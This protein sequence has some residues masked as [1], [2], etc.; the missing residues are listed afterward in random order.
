MAPSH[1]SFSVVSV[2]AV[3]V[4]LLS[5]CWTASVEG[6]VSDSS[7]TTSPDIQRSL[8]SE[9]LINGE[10]SNELDPYFVEWCIEGTCFDLEVAANTEQRMKGLMER[11]VLPEWTGMVFYFDEPGRHAFWM[12]NTLIPLDVIWVWV[13]NTVVDIHT[14]Q[15][16]RS[17]QCPSTI[18][19][20]F[21]DRVIEIN[22]GSGFSIWDRVK[23]KDDELS[24]SAN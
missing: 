14:L 7:T 21:A 6:S 17:E 12:K 20:T 11:P 23:I 24:V 4:V 2:L 19:V 13:D 5:W 8:K 3:T 18:P 15:P 9:L 16:C 10:T 22:A 1:I